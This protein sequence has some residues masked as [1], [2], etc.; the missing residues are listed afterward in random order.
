MLSVSA[1]QAIVSIVQYITLVIHN[2]DSYNKL[3]SALE[4]YL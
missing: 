1:D 4:Y 2:R 3:R